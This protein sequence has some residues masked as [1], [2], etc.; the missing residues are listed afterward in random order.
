MGELRDVFLPGV[1][2]TAP[3]SMWDLQLWRVSTSLM[4]TQMPNLHP[5]LASPQPSPVLS[6]LAQKSVAFP[7]LILFPFLFKSECMGAVPKTVQPY[8]PVFYIHGWILSSQ[9]LYTQN[10]KYPCN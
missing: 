5:F 7:T 6:N 1:G 3:P 9:P 8:T 4:P 2:V 10:S